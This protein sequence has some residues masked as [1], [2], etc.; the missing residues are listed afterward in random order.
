MILK[1]DVNGVYLATLF[2]PPHFLETQ[3]SPE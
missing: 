3:H 2:I 1:T